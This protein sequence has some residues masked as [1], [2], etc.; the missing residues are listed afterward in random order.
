MADLQ[1][2]WI[3]LGEY[4]GGDHSFQQPA[5]GFLFILLGHI[6]ATCCAAFGFLNGNFIS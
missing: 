6:V 2:V 4:C 1:A 3:D 5:L